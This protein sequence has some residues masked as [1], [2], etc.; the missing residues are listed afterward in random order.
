MEKRE[1][2]REKKEGEQV[3]GYAGVCPECGCQ[4]VYQ[5]GCAFCPECGY[6]R[7]F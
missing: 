7:C 5:E 2:Q 4:L 1:E 6:G 3:K